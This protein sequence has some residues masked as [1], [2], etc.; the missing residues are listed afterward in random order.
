[1]T[2]ENEAS[3]E[4]KSRAYDI[5]RLRQEAELLLASIE[6]DTASINKKDAVMSENRVRF[7]RSMSVLAAERQDLVA[8]RTVTASRVKSRIDQLL[9]LEKDDLDERFG[10]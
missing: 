2:D 3:I 7:D 5:E 1:M 6:T 10:L 8:K 9:S 4:N